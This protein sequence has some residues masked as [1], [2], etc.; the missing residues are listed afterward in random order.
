MSPRAFDLEDSGGI[1]IPGP[2]GTLQLRAGRDNTGEVVVGTAGNVAAAGPAPREVVRGVSAA[3]ARDHE[4]ARVRAK[5]IDGATARSELA[6]RLRFAYVRAGKPPLS[7]LGT[8]VGYSKATLSKVFAGKMPPTWILVRK[9]G[10][11]LRVPHHYIVQEWLPLWTAA[12]MHRNRRP[13]ARGSAPVP[14]P[15]SPMGDARTGYPC[16][17]CGSWVVDTTLHTEWHMKMELAGRATPD[18]ESIT[19]WNAQSYE[20][21]LLREA[22]STG[23]EPARPDRPAP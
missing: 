23:Q 16:P 19:G 18:A 15:G 1:R 21:N 4:L 9:L 20:I 10:T 8:A 6:E 7:R 13:T 3:L 17:K 14:A 12:D 5:L 22:L 11:H 2:A